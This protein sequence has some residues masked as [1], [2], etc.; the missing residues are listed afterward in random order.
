MT[1]RLFKTKLTSLLA[2]S[3]LIIQCDSGN[4]EEVISLEE[5]NNKSPNSSLV[6]G[7]S[8]ES[9][10]VTVTLNIKE[11]NSFNLTQDV[12]T[13]LLEGEC[14]DQG[15]LQIVDASFNLKAGDECA[16]QLSSFT[17]GSKNFLRKADDKNVYEH[18]DSGD[19]VLD[20]L[21]MYSVPS[22]FGENDKDGTK[23][24][25]LNGTDPSLQFEFNQI[26][27]GSQTAS[28]D[29]LS[30]TLGNE[31]TISPMVIMLLSTEF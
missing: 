5:D 9:D 12:D 19:T 11:G 7:S 4:E 25:V 20:S 23:S 16:F 31:R 8:S 24:A 14:D 10:V 28:N 17:I 15:S 27:K 26:V 13:F 6:S 30:G 21:D 1:R 22:N 29:A 2:F 18:K 3:F